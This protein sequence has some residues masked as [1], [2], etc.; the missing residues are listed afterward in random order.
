VGGCGGKNDLACLTSTT[1]STR[2]ERLTYSARRTPELLNPP[3]ARLGSPLVVLIPPRPPLLLIF[4]SPFRLNDTLR[5]LLGQRAIRIVPVAPDG[6]NAATPQVRFA[7]GQPFLLSSVHLF[8]PFSF[9]LDSP[10]FPFLCEK[11]AV[12]S[13]LLLCLPPSSSTFLSF[14]P[15]LESRRIRFVLDISLTLTRFLVPPRPASTTFNDEKGASNGR[16]R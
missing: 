16:T 6:R 7:V 12:V 11:T 3:Q 9:A 5:E 2:Q 10:S 15:L 4:L 13:Y 8:A 1:T 14:P